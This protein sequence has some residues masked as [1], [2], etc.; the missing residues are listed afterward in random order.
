MS[1]SY[2][3]HCGR[4][5]SAFAEPAVKPFDFSGPLSTNGALEGPTPF[6]DDV[7]LPDFQS[8]DM[9]IPCA[10]RL[11]SLQPPSKAMHDTAFL[12]ITRDVTGTVLGEGAL[13]SWLAP[14]GNGSLFLAAP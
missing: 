1:R 9:N 2:S 12:T 13:T 14:L 7:L 4:F 10:I 3:M 11:V 6:P 5:D 8:S